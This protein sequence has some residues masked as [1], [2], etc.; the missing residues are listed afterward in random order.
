[1][2]KIIDFFKDVKAE[3]KNITWPK[4]DALI[5]LTI[6]VISISAIISL[7]LGGFD[8]LFTRSLAY[9]AL[10]SKANNI[11]PVIQESTTSATPAT[12]SAIP[13]EIKN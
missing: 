5:H 2:R 9:M 12:D 7:V 1:M 8:Y 4:K 10:P 3:A 6:V 13:V 11:T